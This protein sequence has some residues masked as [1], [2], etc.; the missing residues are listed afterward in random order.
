TGDYVLT[1]L[2]IRE[3][4][5]RIA[6]QPHLDRDGLIAAFYGNYYF[7]VNALGVLLQLCLVSR[8]FRWVGVPG[9]LLVVP[10]VALLG[11]GLVA[12]V[13]VFAVVQAVKLLETSTNYTLMNTARHALYLPLPAAHQYEGK[14]T[15]DGF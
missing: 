4:D 8:L 7:A 12:F 2:V 5:R 6:V 9:A 10:A 13:P 15:I 1:D 14:T 11:Y 3:A